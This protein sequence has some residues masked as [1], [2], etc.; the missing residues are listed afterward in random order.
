[1][2][3]VA[4][5]TLKI[6]I[7]DGEQVAEFFCREGVAIQTVMEMSEAAGKA[8]EDKQ[9]MDGI[10]RRFAEEILTGWNLTEE[11]GSPVPVSAAVFCALPL[12]LRMGAMT[13]WMQQVSSVAAPLGATPAKSDN[14]KPPASLMPV[15]NGSHG[16]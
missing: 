2:G 5:R 8:D 16:S 10:M 15:L 4:R 1:M 7:V 13:Y 9:A 6:E 14:S 11:D 12:S 3:Y